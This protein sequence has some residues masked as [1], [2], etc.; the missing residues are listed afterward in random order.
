MLAVPARRCASQRGMTL[1]EVMVVMV[2]VA[3]LTAGIVV[4]SGQTAPARLKKTAAM[5]TGAVRIA[6]TRASVTAKSQR[7]VFDL[8]EQKMWLEESSQPM[9][10]SQMDAAGG[11]A[12]ATDLE[13]AAAKEAERIVKGPEA[14]KALFTAVTTGIGARAADGTQGQRRLE[15]GIK[16]RSVETQHDTEAVTS[17]RAYL[18]FWP[19]GQTERAVVALRIGDSTDE[20][21]GLSLVVSP[22]TGKVTV[23][24]G[25]V[26]LPRPA[27]D[28]EASEREDTGG[29]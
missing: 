11:A 6:M 18:Y 22:L 9:L 15:S 24:P 26:D 29:P 10:V 16:F 19:G 21:Q 17:G 13:K 23:R 3:L 14:P 25:T 4:G 20:D 2:I 5:V 1:I 8:D 28:R 7:L 12:A 27:D